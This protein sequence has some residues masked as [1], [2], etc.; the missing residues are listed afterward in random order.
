VDVLNSL[1]CESTT[2]EGGIIDLASFASVQEF[3]KKL[4]K[5]GIAIDVLINNAGV[6]MTEF[7]ETADGLETRYIHGLI[8]ACTS[9]L[10]R[11]SC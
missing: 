3:A 1:K 8:S 11:N 7:V 9:I 4:L 2:V 5:R 6:I 10:T